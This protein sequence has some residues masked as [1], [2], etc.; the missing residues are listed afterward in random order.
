M[1]Q[2]HH[3]SRRYKFVGK[4]RSILYDVCLFKNYG[5]YQNKFINTIVLFFKFTSVYTILCNFIYWVKSCKCLIYSSPFRPSL[6]H[7]QA[8]GYEFHVGPYFFWISNPK[9]I[10]LPNLTLLSAM[11]I[12]GLFLTIILSTNTIYIW[13]ISNSKSKQR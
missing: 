12:F 6:W 5:K 8:S 4:K 2:I 13:E 11:Q 10:S 1:V 3:W 7:Q 9:R